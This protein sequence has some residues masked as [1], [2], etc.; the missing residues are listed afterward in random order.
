M[1]PS[2]TEKYSIPTLFE[3]RKQRQHRQFS[4]ENHNSVKS[5]RTKARRTRQAVFNIITKTD[6]SL[7]PKIDIEPTKSGNDPTERQEKKAHRMLIIR[8]KKINK[9]KNAVGSASGEVL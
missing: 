3:P 1:L 7:P 9:H 4:T 6:V 2:C 8:G 5:S